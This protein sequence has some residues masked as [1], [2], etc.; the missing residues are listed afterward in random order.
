MGDVLGHA[1]VRIAAVAWLMV[2]API[3]LATTLAALLSGPLASPGPVGIALTLLRVLTTAGGLMLG[4]H[5]LHRG[6][7]AR[8]WAVAWAAADLGTLGLVLASAQLPSNRAPGDAWLVWLAYAAAA[9]V[10]IAATR[11]AR[12]GPPPA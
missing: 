8:R 12:D 10:V 9:A 5:L 1:L 4:R 11:V 6:G 7:G 3:E 2:I